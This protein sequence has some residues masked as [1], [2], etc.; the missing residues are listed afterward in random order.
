MQ[1][2][3]VM[4]AFDTTEKVPFGEMFP[5][6]D[7]KVR[8]IE[9]TYI[10]AVSGSSSEKKKMAARNAMQSGLK[11]AA[12]SLLRKDKD[13]QIQF[14]FKLTKD[15][16]DKITVNPKY[17]LNAGIIARTHQKGRCPVCG[18]KF[19]QGDVFVVCGDKGSRMVCLDCE[20]SNVVI[21]GAK[22]YVVL[23]V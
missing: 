11:K 5:E 4:N 13:M 18:K 3:K 2:S 12:D 9:K 1:Q 15:I 16:V 20:D 7:K 23:A 21:D 14:P 19:K 10:A 17:Y 22:A 6:E 8:D